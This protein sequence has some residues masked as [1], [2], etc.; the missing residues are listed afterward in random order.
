MTEFKIADPFLRRIVYALGILGVVAF[1]SY[2]FSMIKGFLL[3]SFDSSGTNRRLCQ[4]RPGILSKIPGD[5]PG[6]KI[7]ESNHP[8]K[9]NN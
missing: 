6:L 8:G 4:Y 3:F 1:A 7:S 2:T 5:Y 9:R